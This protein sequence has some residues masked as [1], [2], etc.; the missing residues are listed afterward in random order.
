MENSFKKNLLLD[1]RFSYK[2]AISGRG[3]VWEGSQL[4]SQRLVGS[5]R[6]PSSTLTLCLV[7]E[8]E[9]RMSVREA[10]EWV[11]ITS[12]KRPARRCF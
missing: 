9:S 7:R 4:S 8:T 6:V 3:P 5:I 1:R 11:K 12:E 2:D 10:E